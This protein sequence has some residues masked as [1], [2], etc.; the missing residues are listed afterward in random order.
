MDLAFS[1]GAAAV[2]FL[3]GW[4]ITG[5]YFERRRV[6]RRAQATA[7]DLLRRL[8]R[9][10]DDLRAALR[11]N[12]RFCPVCGHT[13]GWLKNCARCS[14]KPIPAPTRN[15]STWRL[16]DRPRCGYV[17]SC[18]SKKPPHREPPPG[19]RLASVTSM[20]VAEGAWMH[21]Y[22]FRPE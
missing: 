6:I 8:E 15:S 7:D 1:I 3:S 19:H 14:P 21:E 5:W 11:A 13:P 16:R 22:A 12:P 2:F 17:L 9:Q 20:Q 10:R 18:N 4:V